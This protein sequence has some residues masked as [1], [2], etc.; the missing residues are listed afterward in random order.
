M[1]KYSVRQKTQISLGNIKCRINLS[2]LVCFYRVTLMML[3][4]NK[5]A[6]I[7]DTNKIQIK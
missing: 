2:N 5:F 6:A 4:I 1:F 3:I 7:C